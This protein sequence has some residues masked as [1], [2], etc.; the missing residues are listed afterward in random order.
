MT[1]SLVSEAPSKKL[2]HL[3]TRP[4]SSP[5]IAFQLSAMMHADHKVR[6]YL[7]NVCICICDGCGSL[8]PLEP[9]VASSD[10]TVSPPPKLFCAVPST[11]NDEMQHI[12][13]VRC[14]QCTFTTPLGIVRRM[15]RLP[16]C[17]PSFAPTEAFALLSEAVGVPTVLQTMPAAYRSWFL[18]PAC[19]AQGQDA[20][21][22]ML[23]LRDEC[24]I[25]SDNPV[26][27]IQSL[28]HYAVR[29]EQVLDAHFISCPQYPR[30]PFSVST[31]IPDT[32]ND[33]S[34]AHSVVEDSTRHVATL[35][36]EAQ[37][38]CKTVTASDANRK[39][40]ASSLFKMRN[41][42]IEY[43]QEQ[44]KVRLYNHTQRLLLLETS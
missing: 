26:P 5:V 9:V 4:E 40:I 42:S 23:G 41:I 27:P 31:L 10:S 21:L 3:D 1:T 18:D 28:K 17:G 36:S 30:I 24:L 44:A 16:S 13:S 19:R 34:A 38:L 22:S 6:I 32:S 2:T 33:E 43:Q 15:L 25:I 8:L 35:I 14:D 29:A 11:G 20:L 39:E 7:N 12:N 37:F